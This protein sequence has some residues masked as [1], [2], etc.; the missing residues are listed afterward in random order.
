LVDDSTLRVVTFDPTGAATEYP[1]HLV[2][3]C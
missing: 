1:F 2:V 3:F